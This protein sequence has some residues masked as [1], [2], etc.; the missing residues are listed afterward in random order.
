MCLLVFYILGCSTDSTDNESIFPVP[1]IISEEEQ[2]VTPPRLP[3]EM[4]P[5]PVPQPIVEEAVVEEPEP[6][7]VVEEP[8]PEPIEEKRKSQKIIEHRFLSV[9]P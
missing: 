7:P 2:E 6:E 9:P 3:V 1:P 8:E 4:V 5:P